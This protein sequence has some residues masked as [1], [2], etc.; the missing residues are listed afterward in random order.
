MVARGAR[1]SAGSPTRVSGLQDEAATGRPYGKGTERL[2]DSAIELFGR[3]GFEATSVRAVADHAGVSF[4]LIRVSYGSKEGLRDAAE[5]RVF[6]EWAGLLA[7]SGDVTSSAEQLSFLRRHADDVARLKAHTRF[8]RRS[9]LEDRPIANAFLRRF[10]N[11][12]M[13]TPLAHLHDAYPNETFLVN[14]LRNFMLGI[15]FILI[16]PNIADILGRDL[17]APSEYEALNAEEVR[18]ISLIEQGLRAE[19]EGERTS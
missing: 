4:A 19:S 17:L 7:Y 13:T 11:S 2:L 3:D 8:I 16:A 1:K 10:L 15:G 12:R 14:P 9:I 6:S 5:Q 18:I